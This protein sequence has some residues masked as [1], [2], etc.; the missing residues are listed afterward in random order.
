MAKT[1]VYY[2]GAGTDIVSGTPSA[3][4][5]SALAARVTALEALVGASASAGLRKSVA[6]LETIVG[7]ETAGLVKRVG[8][9]EEAAETAGSG[10]DS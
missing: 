9:L 8:D 7:D 10:S 5:Y 3:A 4:Q 1:S 6:D 2:G